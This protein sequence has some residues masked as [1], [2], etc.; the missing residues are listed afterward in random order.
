MALALAGQGAGIPRRVST[1]QLPADLQ[2]AKASGLPTTCGPPADRGLGTLMIASSIMVLVVADAVVFI[3]T[4]WGPKHGGINALNIDLASS[5][6]AHA[7]VPVF[8]FAANPLDVDRENAVRAN[9]SLLTIPAECRDGVAP[10]LAQAM[11]DELRHRAPNVRH[12]CWVGHDLIS[13]EAMLAC[14]ELCPGTSVLIQH[15]DYESYEVLKDGDGESALNKAGRQIDLVRK[16]M[17]VAGVGPKLASLARGRLEEPAKNQVLE[18]IPGVPAIEMGV[19]PTAFSAIAF[20]RF[21]HR[22]E[23][24][25]R[26]RLAVAGFARAIRNDATILGRDCKLTL[27]GLD[28]DPALLEDLNA[29]AF[30]EAGR[31]VV[32]NAAPFSESREEVFQLLRRQSMA[33]MLSFHEGFG[34]VGWEAIA[35]GVPLVVSQNSGLYELLDNRMLENRVFSVDVR[36]TPKPGDLNADDIASVAHQ[37][38]AI[39][40]APMK[41][42]E[43][44]QSLAREMKGL[45]TWRRCAVQLATAARVPVSRRPHALLLACGHMPVDVCGPSDAT[46]GVLP[47]HTQDQARRIWMLTTA[48]VAQCVASLD[49]PSWLLLFSGVDGGTFAA[50]VV[51]EFIDVH[52]RDSDVRTVTHTTFSD[53]QEAQAYF[54]KRHS[55]HFRT[56]NVDP[57]RP[58]I[59]LPGTV[60]RTPGIENRRN[61]M[62]GQADAVMCVAGQGPVD[63][64][65]DLAIARKLPLIAIGAFGGGTRDRLDTIVDHNS[66]LALPEALEKALL[67]LARAPLDESKLLPAIEHAFVAFSTWLG[68]RDATV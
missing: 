16:S 31:N 17:V 60:L 38:L 57:S 10:V 29:L 26:S 6:A 32:I 62:V 51:H 37:V 42:R 15:M 25:K 55:E 61:L 43:K 49:H 3:A 13:G 34:L 24:V 4:A 21:D 33:M 12:P 54:A 53:D 27:L 65:I 47:T 19:P 11:V 9:V 46:A 59:Y 23:P 44:A 52:H 7:D 66:G 39:A 68:S 5:M 64:M 2:L 20:G 41:A 1:I 56:H 8:C 22:T 48:K 45:F 63:H 36:G 14:Q 30:A 67:E 50:G 58:Y 18:L 40:R 35:A 28:K